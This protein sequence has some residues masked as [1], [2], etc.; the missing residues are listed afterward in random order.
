M[1]G[2]NFVGDYPG[3]QSLEWIKYGF[4]QAVSFEH[5]D[6]WVNKII[7]GY[8]NP[9]G[10]LLNIK[11]ITNFDSGVSANTIM[12]AYAERV[13]RANFNGSSVTIEY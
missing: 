4:L 10:N 6:A 2:N 1:E 13:V 5:R 11:W 7:S 9:N 8:P 3:L 12:L